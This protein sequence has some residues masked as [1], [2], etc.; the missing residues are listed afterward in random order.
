VISDTQHDL[1]SN[2]NLI[3]SATLLNELALD[4]HAANEKWWTDLETGKPKQRNVGEMLMLM[5]S[6]LAEA[7]EGD[8]KDLMD[9][10]LPHRKMLEVELA[11]ALIRG[12]DL[13]GHRVKD[14]SHFRLMT[15]GVSI[16][17]TTNAA[18]NLFLLTRSLVRLWPNADDAMIWS[19]WFH[20]LFAFAGVHKLDLWGAYMEKMDYN[21]TRADHQ[22]DARLAAGGKKY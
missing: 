5:V 22:R 13:A 14:I 15:V 1:V 21:K 17:F 3:P 20:N 6:E 9:D 10:K 16:Q 2:P 7:M 12:L 4:V 8:R 18:E 19:I 11:D